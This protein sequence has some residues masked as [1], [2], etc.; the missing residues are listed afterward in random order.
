MSERLTEELFLKESKIHI[1]ENPFG[2]VY[3]QGG[4]VFKELMGMRTTLKVTL[5]PSDNQIL[6]GAGI[7]IF[8]Q[9]F[10]PT[11]ISMFFAWPVLITQIWGLVKQAELDNRALEIASNYCDNVIP[12]H[13][14]IE[15]NIIFCTN[16]GSKIDISCKYCSYCG[17]K[18][19]DRNIS[20]ES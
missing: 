7:G 18:L 19:S 11:I 4:G 14:L 2:F 20:Y 9:Q 13:N 12:S 10:L 6:F 3:E 1:G 5:I 17:I 8:G 16:C 15:D